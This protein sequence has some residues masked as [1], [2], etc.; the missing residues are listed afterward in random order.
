MAWIHH[1]RAHAPVKPCRETIETS[2][3]ALGVR[4]PAA[5]TPPSAPPIGPQQVQAFV[6]ARNRARW[7]RARL[8]Q[9]GV[10]RADL[11]KVSQTASGVVPGASRMREVRG[12]NL[13]LWGSA[14]APL[15]AS[16]S[17]S[18]SHGRVHGS[19]RSRC[20]APRPRPRVQRFAPPPARRE[21]QTAANC[22][23]ARALK[24][25]LAARAPPARGARPRRRLGL[26]C[27]AAGVWPRGRVW[28]RAGRRVAPRI[29]AITCDS[30]AL[31]A[32]FWGGK[33]AAIRRADPHAVAPTGATRIALAAWGSAGAAVQPWRPRATASTCPWNPS[34]Q[35]TCL[36]AWS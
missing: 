34:S 7:R 12:D 28:R 3:V 1:Q 18:A 31:P 29:S 19:R 16:P 33:A 8:T 2:G 14:C 24:G 4:P 5:G 9:R 21:A 10:Q 36:A 22:C 13:Y 27:D 15:R 11:P 17:F 25:L 32:L 30:A 20:V 6:T 26:V 23:R 35:K